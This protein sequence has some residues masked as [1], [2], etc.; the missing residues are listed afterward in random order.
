MHQNADDCIHQPDQRREADDSGII[1][2]LI[3]LQWREVVRRTRFFSSL[4]FY[5]FALFG[6]GEATSS[7]KRGSSGSH[8][9]VAGV[10]P[11][12]FRA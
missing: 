11:E 12:G 8:A 10:S 6:V 3:R 4:E 7:W 1:Q 9:V 5:R 2:W